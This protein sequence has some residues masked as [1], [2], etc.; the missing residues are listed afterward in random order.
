ME[1]KYRNIAHRYL[2]QSDNLAENWPHFTFDLEVIAH[3]S[4]FLNYQRINPLPISSRR[5]TQK[6]K[7]KMKNIHA[8]SHGLQ[9]WKRKRKKQKKAMNVRRMNRY[10][11]RQITV[12]VHFLST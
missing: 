9:N 10:K 8:Y 6:L 1:V 7:L 5:I 4:L 11:M 2:L 12:S 3:D